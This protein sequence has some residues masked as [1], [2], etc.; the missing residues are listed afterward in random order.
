[1]LSQFGLLCFA[2]L[3]IGCKSAKVSDKGYT[4]D[5]IEIRKVKDNVY[6]HITYLQTES[7]GRVPCNGI[8]FLNKGEAVVFDTPI[9]DSTSAELIGWVRDSLR[10]KVVAVV[11][12]HFHE[13][14]LGGLNAFHRLGIP[15]YASIGTIDSARARK[16]PVPEKGFDGLLELKVGVKKVIVDY[17]GEGHTR[18][19]VIGYFPSEKVM[20]GGCLIKEMN[21]SKGYLGDANVNEWSATVSKIKA[22]YPDTQLVVPGHGKSGGVEL[23]DYTIK[24]FERKK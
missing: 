3:L 14:C 19:N 1:M 13:D 18:H 20:F 6:Q 2:L 23:L 8:I 24:L 7:F 16:Y 11:P 15:S 17:N 4:S 5:R 9:D 10:G 12:T 21:A 22:K